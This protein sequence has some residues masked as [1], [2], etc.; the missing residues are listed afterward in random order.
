MIDLGAWLDGKYKVISELK[1]HEHTES[2]DAS[3]D[4]PGREQ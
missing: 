3:T 1:S 2:P 4:V